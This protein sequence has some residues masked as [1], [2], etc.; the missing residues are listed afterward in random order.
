M[1][2][3]ARWRRF[4]EA[5]RPELYGIYPCAVP[6]ERRWCPKHRIR[7][8][9]SVRTPGAWVRRDGRAHRAKRRTLQLSGICKPCRD[10]L[11][12]QLAA[13]YLIR[14]ERRTTMHDRETAPVLRILAG[15]AKARGT[16]RFRTADAMQLLLVSG[17]EEEEATDAA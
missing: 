2:Q 6:T 17:N 11:Y 7:V 16:R 5:R 9:Q 1:N 14:S 8:P 13:E 15:R 10:E 3:K 12:Q 4:V